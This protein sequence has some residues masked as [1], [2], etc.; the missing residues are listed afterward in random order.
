MAEETQYTA[1][2][3]IVTISTANRYLDGSG[4]LG[5][6]IAGSSPGT[7]VK[8]LAIKAMGNTTRGMIR[9]F[10]FN[11]SNSRLF[12]E[13]EVPPN[14]ASGDNPTFEAQIPVELTLNSS[15]YIKVSTDK[16]ETF[17]IFAEGMDWAYNG[18]SVRPDTTEFYAN[19]HSGQIKDANS[20]LDGSGATSLIFAAG[21]S[22]T[23][24]GSSIESITIKAVESV[25]YGMVRLFVDDG[26]SKHLF[27]EVP[28]STVTYSKID[29]AYVCRL[30]FPDDFDLQAGYSL[31]ASTQNENMFYVTTKGADFKYAT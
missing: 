20:N 25:A 22:S 11:G 13:V 27:M 4:T 23:Y 15:S 6:L 1:K 7:L 24:K 8:S 17:K 31:Y 28:V 26:S 9:F 10:V 2:T 30:D 29:Q 14:T 3:G 19:T 16:G 18:S 12:L 5:T 21:S